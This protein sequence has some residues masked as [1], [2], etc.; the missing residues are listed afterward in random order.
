VPLERAVAGILAFKQ[1]LRKIEKRK[2]KK[3]AKQKYVLML[4]GCAKYISTLEFPGQAQ[5]DEA[6][7][8]NT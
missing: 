4:T 1:A 6:V 5:C 3:Q 8:G 2:I 7:V